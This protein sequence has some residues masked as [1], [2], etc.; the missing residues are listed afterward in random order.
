MFMSL[1]CLQDYL[2]GKNGDM[3]WDMLQL[4]TQI[5]DAIPIFEYLHPGAVGIWVFDVRLHMK[6]LL[7]MRSMSRI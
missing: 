3:W 6:P 7:R 1:K 5:K 4:L 2:P